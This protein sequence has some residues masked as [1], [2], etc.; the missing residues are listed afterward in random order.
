MRVKKADDQSSAF[1]RCESGGDPSARFEGKGGFGGGGGVRD[2]YRIVHRQDGIVRCP[3]Q[4]AAGFERDCLAAAFDE[5]AQQ[6]FGHLNFGRMA[7][8]ASTFL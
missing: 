4:N 5:G 3:E 8:R 7:H 1:L 2:K 6:L